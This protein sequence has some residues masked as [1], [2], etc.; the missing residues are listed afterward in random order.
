MQRQLQVKTSRASQKTK[1]S[2]RVSKAGIPGMRKLQVAGPNSLSW[3]N[4]PFLGPKQHFK[5]TIQGCK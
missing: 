5:I 4:G 1:R 2:R 3:D